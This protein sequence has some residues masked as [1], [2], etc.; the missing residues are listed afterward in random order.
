MTGSEREGKDLLVEA[1]KVYRAW[2]LSKE[3]EEEKR[4]FYQVIYSLHQAEESIE[5]S[6]NKRDEF[7][8]VY[9][10][11]EYLDDLP[12]VS[13]EQIEDKDQWPKLV[14]FV[15]FFWSIKEMG[16]N[17]ILSDFDLDKDLVL[18]CF[19]VWAGKNERRV[20]QAAS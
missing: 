10:L 18:D 15:L 9:Q 8:N 11:Q 12:R 1:G 19:E 3:P 6:L 16:V 20:I 4:F 17:Q 5:S 7:E 13:Q 2:A 14:K